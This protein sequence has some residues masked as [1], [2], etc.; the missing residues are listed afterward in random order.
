MPSSHFSIAVNTTTRL[1]NY[2]NLYALFFCIQ[3]LHIALFYLFLKFVDH[4]WLLA[5]SGVLNFAMYGY[6]SWVEFRF[7]R[8][9][10]NPFAIYLGMSSIRLGVAVIYIAAVIQLGYVSSSLFTMG[11]FDASEWLM[12]GQLI[13]MIGDWFFISGFFIVSRRLKVS[14]YKLKSGSNMQ[15]RIYYSGLILAVIGFTVRVIDSNINLGG[16]GQITSYFSTY[17]PPGGV[18]IM[19]LNIRTRNLNILSIDGLI[20]IM[21]LSFDI[22]AGLGS[23]MKS[24]LLISLLPLPIYF[25][26][27]GNRGKK[28]KFVSLSKTSMFLLALMAY[29]FLFTM[30]SYSELRRPKYWDNMGRF[31]TLPSAEVMPPIWPDLSSALQ[32]SIPGTSKFTELHVFPDK[33]VWNILRRLAVTQLGAMSYGLVETYGAREDSFVKAVAYGIIPRVIFPDKA[34]ISPGADTAVLLGQ[35]RTAESATSATGLTM[36]GYYYYWGGIGAVIFGMFFSGIGL[37]IVWSKIRVDWVVNPIT[38]LLMIVLVYVCLHWFENGAFGY[39]PFYI[40]IFVIFIPLASFI[41]RFLNI[42]LFPAK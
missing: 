32:G 41:R 34:Q 33:G 24:D 25:V 35:A 9:R 30:S 3:F 6:M 5:I 8:D 36:H 29:F 22:L 27:S 16:L 23:Y 26:F 38:A 12:E 40:Y 21:L 13:I 31:E 1:A 20:P 2:K 4:G 7:G 37:A 17:G 14:N 28:W 39:F 10:I 11:S 42:K 15:L 19:L 18:L